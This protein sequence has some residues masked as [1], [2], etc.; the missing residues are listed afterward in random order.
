MVGARRPLRR[1]HARAANSNERGDSRI[2][3]SGSPALRGADSS[4]FAGLECLVEVRGLDQSL[5][6]RE[7]RS[8]GPA[9]RAVRVHDATQLFE[10]GMEPLQVVLELLLFLVFLAD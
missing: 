8:L 3:P 4:S 9:K 7:A 5:V 2:L 1:R 10:N 6:R